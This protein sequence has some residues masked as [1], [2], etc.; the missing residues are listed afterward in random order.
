MNIQ[1]SEHDWLSLPM[2]IRVK[3]RQLF[4]VPRSKGTTMEGGV[5]K[6]DGTTYQDLQAITLEKMQQYLGNG[7][8]N[9]GLLF[10]LVI[11]R[12][13]DEDKELE[14]PQVER[15]TAEI[16]LEEWIEKLSKMK[17][18]AASANLSPHLQKAIERIFN[19]KLKNADAN[20]TK[21]LSKSAKKVHKGRA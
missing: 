16:L 20:Q 1:V 21:G 6:S 14:P 9:F 2:P 7:D 5:V 13:T 3:L 4:S 17:V 10:D 12:L 8:P 19:I 15:N 18:Q 11:Q